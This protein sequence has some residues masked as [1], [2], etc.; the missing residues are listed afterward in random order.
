LEEAKKPQDKN[1]VKK[2]ENQVFSKEYRE[3]LTAKMLAFSAHL[4]A[5]LY[6]IAEFDDGAL[7]IYTP[8]SYWFKFESGVV[9]QSPKDG[10]AK[11]TQVDRLGLFFKLFDL[12]FRRRLEL[13]KRNLNVQPK[14]TDSGYILYPKVAQALEKVL[15]PLTVFKWSE[16]LDSSMF[17]ACS[18]TR[19]SIA[20]W[21]KNHP[22][23]H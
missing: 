3:S 10:D 19:L 7:Q 17:S 12:D 4:S 22:N 5:V 1:K 15:Y 18:S 11:P 20:R 9:D 6:D 13:Q 23:S 8:A 16:A 21:N 14:F 2:S